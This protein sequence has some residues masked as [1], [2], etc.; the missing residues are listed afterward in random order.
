M[1]A[2]ASETSDE[3]LLHAWIGGDAPAGEMLVRRHYRRILMFFYAR[4]G[5]EVG[6]DLTQATFETLCSNKP[7]F[8]GGS[9]VRTYLFGIARWKLVHHFRTLRGPGADFEPLE[10]SG[11][12]PDM[13]RSITSL[14]MGRQRETLLVQ[15]LRS[16]PLD[17]QIV[18]ELKEHEGMTSRELAAVFE[19]GRDTMSSR[20][21]RA[22][23]RLAAA[24]AELAE[25][26]RLC[27]ST[28]TGLAEGM[29]EIRERVAAAAGERTRSED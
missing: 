26:A 12:L 7:S 21:N 23:K 17:D 5:A 15:A 10:H 1:S 19:V 29:Q 16:L 25:S 3:A 22:R 11:D 13:A 20:I 9:S 2:S 4:V 6:R 18:L 27:D 8:R 24:V 14:F 28:L